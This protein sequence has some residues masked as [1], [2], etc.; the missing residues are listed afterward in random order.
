MRR[1]IMY[2][3]LTAVTI[4]RRLTNRAHWLVV[5]VV[6]TSLALAPL[7]PFDGAVGAQAADYDLDVPGGAHFYTQTNGG[8]GTTGYAVSN[9]DGIPFWTFFNEVGGVNA[10]GYP[11]SHR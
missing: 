8:A 5:A 4:V 11:V 1:R 9:A 6:V 7:W 10:V 2:P 3:G